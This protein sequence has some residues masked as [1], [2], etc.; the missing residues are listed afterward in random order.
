M[1]ND[2]LLEPWRKPIPVAIVPKPQVAEPVVNDVLL[3]PWP[4]RGTQPNEP[5]PEITNAIDAAADRI[6]AERV[7]KALVRENRMSLLGKMKAL[8]ES[9]SEFNKTTELALDGIAEKIETAKVK[10]SAAVDKH[11]GYYDTLIKGIEES[12]EVIDKLSNGAP[13]DEDGAN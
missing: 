13:L 1:A 7:V 2:M 8:T 12:T 4:L 6:V 11:H 5:T 9:A 3:D 10:R